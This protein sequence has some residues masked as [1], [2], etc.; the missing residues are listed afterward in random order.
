[1]ST[2]KGKPAGIF[3]P[4]IRF[5]DESINGDEPNW[6]E[7]NLFWHYLDWFGYTLMHDQLYFTYTLTGDE[8]LL[9]PLFATLDLIAGYRIDLDKPAAVF[10]RVL[11]A[12]LRRGWIEAMLSGI[13]SYSGGFL[14]ATR[15]TTN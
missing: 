12:G 5:V 2:G 3:P 7:A 11:P 15:A 1:M 13:W 9:Q 4:S 14:P 10:E 6:Y 8:N